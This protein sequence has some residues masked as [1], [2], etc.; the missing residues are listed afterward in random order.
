MV[1]WYFATL[2]QLCQI[3][4]SV[5]VATLQMLVVAL[6]HPRLDYDNAVLVG[7]PAYLQ[8]RLGV[9]CCGMAYLLPGFQWPH[10][11]RSHQPPLVASSRARQ[12]QRGRADIQGSPQHCAALPSA[13]VTNRLAMPSVCLYTV[14]NRAFLVVAPAIWNSLPDDIVSSANLSTFCR[15]L[16]TFLFSVSFSDLIL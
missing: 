13:A 2:R 14:G 15:Q 16:K 6:V 7:I 11:W 3:L 8:R 10:H 9:K 5:Q 12:V 4:R 1:S